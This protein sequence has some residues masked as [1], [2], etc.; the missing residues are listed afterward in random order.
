MNLNK[1][2][3]AGFSTMLLLLLALAGSAQADGGHTANIFVT[4][5]F[6][7]NRHYT[8]VPPAGWACNLSSGSGDPQNLSCYDL[9]VGVAHCGTVG[10]AV[11]GLSG[12]GQ[13]EAFAICGNAQSAC[14]AIVVLTTVVNQPCGTSVTGNGIPLCNWVV[15][16]VNLGLNYNAQCTFS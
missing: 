4:S 3:A 15:L 5:D 7:G 9:A 14:T 2:I 8:V 16:P 11:N 6:S 12:T 10:V 13:V 1:P